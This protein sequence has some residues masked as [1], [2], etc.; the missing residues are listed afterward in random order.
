MNLPTGRIPLGVG[1]SVSAVITA[2]GLGFG[3][4]TWVW[5]PLAAILGPAVAIVLRSMLLNQLTDPSPVP[6]RPSAPIGPPPP[7]P[8]HE[9]ISDLPLPTSEP[10]YRFQF[11]A[12]VSCL[13]DPHVPPLHADL[14]VLAKQNVIARALERAR[15]YGPDDYAMA[16]VDLA[17]ALAERI[18]LANGHYVWASDV[19]VTLSNTDSE[20][21]DTM[22]HLRKEKALWELKRAHELAARDYVGRE[23]LRDPGTAVKW[24][25]GR[26]LDD[27]KAPDIAVRSIDD[28]C[29]I[30]SEAHTTDVPVWEGRVHQSPAA[31]PPTPV[32]LPALSDPTDTAR[33]LKSVLATLSEDFESPLRATLRRRVADLLRK[34]GLTEAADA[35]SDPDCVEEV[36][37][38]VGEGTDGYAGSESGVGD[39]V[40]V[41]PTKADS[42][43]GSGPL[44]P[45]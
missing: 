25:F 4:A 1:A 14:R 42:P 15:R 3:W 31:L 27:A 12:T 19:A 20:R 10:D 16:T 35:L 28:L 34:Y 13:R 7:A 18:T 24:W 8:Q 17:A 33:H 22:A 26:H 30:T 9:K 36:Q 41:E 38:H 29:T 45:E 40:P 37:L 6:S 43:N 44:S 39:D 5:V 11:S 32:D 2:L 23:V 21:L